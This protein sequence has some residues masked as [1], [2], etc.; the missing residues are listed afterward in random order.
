MTPEFSQKIDP[1][2]EYVLRLLD[3]IDHS[4]AIA[5]EPEKTRILAMLDKAEAA[6]GPTAEW[7]L[8]KFALV[9][10]IDEM[11]LAA[12][13]EG[14]FWW[15]ESS[16]ETAV[17]SSRERATEYF[18]KARD[19]K[20]K[21]Q[22]NALEVFYLG[23]ILGFRGLYENPETAAAE[24]ARL[25]LPEELSVWVQQTAAAIRER[26]KPTISPNR[27]VGFGAP[28]LG[29]Q[30][31]LIGSLLAVAVMSAVTLITAYVVFFANSYHG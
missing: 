29:G 10:W 15:N 22:R 28:P 20:E 21:P 13:W 14:R 4:E 19:A 3:R 2:F 16:L 17:F 5:P 27:E 30:A 18:I 6:L 25:E 1:I 12:P 23:V 31:L 7:Q 24:T 8:A 9:C 26:P 11:L